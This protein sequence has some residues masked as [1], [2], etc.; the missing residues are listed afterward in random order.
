MINIAFTVVSLIV[1]AAAVA[2]RGGFVE[3]QSHISNVLSETSESSPTP[4][5]ESS[6]TPLETATPIP[7]TTAK[8]TS[9]PTPH[10]TSTSSATITPSFSISSWVYPSA[11]VAS[12]SNSKVNLTSS[13]NA[14]TITEWYRQRMKSQG[15]GSTSVAQTE[16]NH[17]VLNKLAGAT[18]D[19]SV[20]IEITQENSGA[21]V[22]I[23][24]ELTASNSS[25]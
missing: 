16:V 8:P 7:T 20:K 13:D 25:I 24:V 9:S 23:T 1:L 17:K 10:P 18:N 12:Q 14:K 6:P 5:E 15:Y 11:S 21:T 4:T 2:V 19:S 22:Y 3:N